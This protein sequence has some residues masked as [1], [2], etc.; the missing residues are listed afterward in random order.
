MMKVKT[1]L[2]SEFMNRNQRQ[3]LDQILQVG[4]TYPGGGNSP[5]SFG[6]GIFLS[7]EKDLH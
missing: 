3:Y 6:E 7:E 1:I 4:L 5:C 2:L